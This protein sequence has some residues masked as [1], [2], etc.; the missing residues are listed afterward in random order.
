[1][2][3]AIQNNHFPALLTFFLCAGLFLYNS[4]ALRASDPEQVN[5][6]DS[7]GPGSD[8]L[9][10]K[11]TVTHR[12]LT[13]ACT[14]DRAIEHITVPTLTPFIPDDPNGTAVV[15]CPGGAY[16]R[17][18][19]DVEGCDIARWYNQFGVT[20]FVLKYRLPVDKHMESM[21]VPLQDAQRAMRFVKKNAATW[22]IDTTKIGIMGASAGG[23]LAASLG[24]DFDKLVYAP[25]DAIDSISARPGFM[26]LLYPV[27]S[28]DSSITHTGSR[29]NL[30]GTVY[31]QELLDE[32]SAE[33]HV[34][35]NTPA[36]FMARAA[37]DYGVNQENCN[38]FDEALK[39]AGVSSALHIYANGGHGIGICKAV[40]TDF[41]NWTRDCQNWLVSMDLIADSFYIT[42]AFDGFHDTFGMSM[43]VYPNPLQSNSLLAYRVENGNHVDISVFDITGNIIHRLID[44]EQKRGSHSIEIRKEM[45]PKEGFYIIRYCDSYN[46]AEQKVV[47]LK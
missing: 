1:M 21:Y 24:T 7:T 35:F 42:A 13:G 4:Y 33:K 27:I 6:W 46:V 10:I 28:M 18:V 3:T 30:L 43:H 23:H 41:A 22:G 25:L 12:V 32:F 34:T 40:G 44:G 17:V 36:T 19:Y 9:T 38:R 47:V 16:Q 15:I 11:E 5:I 26:V 31:T 2:N 37:D 20:A 14:I 39:N 45:F 8:T 29:Q